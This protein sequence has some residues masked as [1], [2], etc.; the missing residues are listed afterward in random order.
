MIATALG[1]RTAGVMKLIECVRC[2]GQLD[3]EATIYA[4]EPWTEDS[5]PRF[6]RSIEHV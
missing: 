4:A 5:Q 2:L 6:P 1:P 3:R